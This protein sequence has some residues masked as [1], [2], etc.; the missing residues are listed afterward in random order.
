M[1]IYLVGGAVRDFL[2]QRPVKDRDYVVVGA[3]PQQMLDLGF[4][5][6]GADFPVFL[7][8]ESNEEYAL[9]RTERKTGKGYN[10][11]ETT[12]DPT[13]TL[14][15]DLRRRDLTINAMA[16]DIETGEIIDPFN[17]RKDLEEETLRHVSSAFAEDPLRVLRVARFV[18]RYG[19]AIADETF[20]MMKHLVS[21]GEL[22][23]LTPERVWLEME[24]GFGETYPALFVVTLFRL[25]A[26]QT[27][28][29]IE[30]QGTMGRLLVDNDFTFNQKMMALC[31]DTPTDV[32]KN[33]LEKY[34]ASV[35]CIRQV[36]MFKRLQE[37][38]ETAVYARTSAGDLYLESNYALLVLKQL[39]AFRRPD[40]FL[41]LVDPACTF[42][43]AGLDWFMEFL[44]PYFNIMKT[45]TFSS[46][47]A[48]QQVTLKGKE[49]AEAID[50]ERINKTRG[51]YDG[52]TTHGVY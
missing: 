37:A 7:H 41:A 23:N 34:K 10:G 21:S 39:D 50:A 44:V 26:W 45:V 2:L 49:I 40:D 31:A 9:A 33:D 25:G 12:F 1:K 4:S 47:T 13:I 27:L 16:M 18:A 3:T 8:P 29:D 19:F 17:G 43:N 52:L 5:R 15:D 6:V 20:D 30:V 11:F 51:M 28:F 24:K 22:N 46:L 42:K 36:L 14:E 38:C 48:E 32:V 35:D